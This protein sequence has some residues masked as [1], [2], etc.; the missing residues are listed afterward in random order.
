MKHRFSLNMAFT[1]KVRRQINGKTF[2]HHTSYTRTSRSTA[3]I[4]LIGQ[5]H[6]QR[7]RPYLGSAY[8]NGYL[9]SD[10][11]KMKSYLKFADDRLTPETAKVFSS[12]LANMLSTFAID[13]PAEELEGINL[14]NASK[15]LRNLAKQVPRQVELV[16]D[17][18]VQAK[19]FYPASCNLLKFVHEVRCNLF[20][21][22]KTQ[23]KLLNDA[24]QRRLLI[25]A[26]ILI[27]ANGLLFEVANR[28]KIGWRSVEVDFD[29]DP[30]F[31]TL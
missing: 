21:G 6:L 8:A 19:D 11:D 10:E 14:V 9:P 25:Y 5:T 18:Q 17:Q 7:I 27:A 15:K 3:Y 16:Q 26:A 24:Q 12:R 31:R 28:E 2:R 13:N 4:L 23:V 20:H 29:S 1:Y 22:R 30:S